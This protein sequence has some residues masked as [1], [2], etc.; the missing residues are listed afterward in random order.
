MNHSK[1]VHLF[2]LQC[3]MCTI[4]LYIYTV[5]LWNGFPDEI[6]E[7]QSAEAFVQRLEMY[8]QYL[9]DWHISVVANFSAHK[10]WDIVNIRLYLRFA[11]QMCLHIWY[12]DMFLSLLLLSLLLYT[13]C[14]SRMVVCKMF[15][16]QLHINITMFA[17]ENFPILRILLSRGFH[18][19]AIQIKLQVL[20]TIMVGS[21]L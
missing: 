7:V 1:C 6:V 11:L 2:L 13:Y 3:N 21:I 20:R 17:A 14:L 5:E 18:V 15:H 19:L 12:I 9:S 16:V 10:I 4:F 8:L